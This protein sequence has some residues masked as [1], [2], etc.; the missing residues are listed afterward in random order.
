M[1]PG[2]L[3]ALGSGDGDDGGDA[4]GAVLS[5]EQAATPTAS[6]AAPRE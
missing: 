4:A 3:G 1:S 5:P 2:A 6:A